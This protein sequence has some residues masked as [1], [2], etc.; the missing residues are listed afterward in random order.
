MGNA[1]LFAVLLMFLSPG[2]LNY[3]HVAVSEALNLSKTRQLNCMLV[4]EVHQPIEA[5]SHADRLVKRKAQL[6]LTDRGTSLGD[7]ADQIITFIVTDSS[8]NILKHVDEDIEKLDCEIQ[9]YSTRGIEVEWPG[10]QTEDGI[11]YTWFIS[12]IKHTGD[13]FKV[14]VF[15]RLISSSSN[16]N[17]E[18]NQMGQH[19]ESVLIGDS[20]ILQVTGV[21]IVSTK[22]PVVE[23]ELGRD[24]LLDC[25]FSADHK[26]D[27]NIEWRL[28]QKGTK[29]KLFSYSSL[30][31][32]VEHMENRTEVFLN[33]FSRGNASLLIRDVGIK[34]A[35]TYICVV[36]VP[37]LYE[38]IE[39]QVD[40][41][42]SPT[43]SVNIDHLSMIEGVEEKLV[44]DITGYYPLDVQVQWLR[45][46]EREHLIPEV[47]KNI[48]Y[49]SHKH[50]ADG[51]FSISSF[52]WLRAHPRDDGVKYT[53]R[54]EHKS[55][56][57]AI[58]Q[59]IFVTVKVQGSFTTP[60]LI[61]FILILLL[62]L[63]ILLF[64]LHKASI[65]KKKPY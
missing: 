29:K 9:R 4:E 39:V 47:M 14:A 32:H 34:D 3:E 23:S 54:V 60:L 35:G 56:K 26:V 45:E 15:F 62:I 1:G 12:I 5:G 37:P 6:L 46:H 24:V 53:C 51:T 40:I 65:N 44:C 64:Y 17:V 38:D 61:I 8:I 58:R 31:K 18:S 27:A 22:T 19:S 42:A 28:Q 21:Y 49:S 20:D 63:M 52:F 10:I 2:I 55:L 57:T 43:V 36:Y 30:S 16:Q 25:S 50:N 33:E 48:L 41:L 59:S 7:S 11:P 13:Q